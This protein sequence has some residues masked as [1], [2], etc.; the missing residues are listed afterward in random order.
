MICFSTPL[1]IQRKS[2]FEQLLVVVRKIH[3]LS[4]VVI[5]KINMQK[6]VTFLYIN[7][8]LSEREI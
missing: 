6:P 2:K 4:E 1:L 3:K 8:K 5:Y 7:N